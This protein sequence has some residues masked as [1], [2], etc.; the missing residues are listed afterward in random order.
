MYKHQILTTEVA[1]R[2]NKEMAKA[3]HEVNEM[4]YEWSSEEL[5]KLIQLIAE[6]VDS[7]YDSRKADVALWHKGFTRHNFRYYLELIE[8]D[9]DD[10][11]EDEDE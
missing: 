2:L 1:V 6:W 8:E 5:G 10:S 9:D 7:D 11:D 3:I 4:F